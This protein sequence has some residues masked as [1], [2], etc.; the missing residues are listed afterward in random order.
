MRAARLR[1]RNERA[2]EEV[3]RVR[4]LRAEGAHLG[5]ARLG[6]AAVLAV[7]VDARREG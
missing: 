4:H 2:V 1:D 6:E 7:D 5:G 3:V